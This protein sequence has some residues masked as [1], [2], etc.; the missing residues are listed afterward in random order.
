MK[1][2]KIYRN[3]WG[4]TGDE[5]HVMLPAN[6][7]RENTCRSKH[8]LFPLPLSHRPTFH[9]KEV[10]E[11][12]NSS[13]VSELTSVK[14]SSLYLKRSVIDNITRSITGHPYE[15]T[16]SVRASGGQ[17]GGAEDGKRTAIGLPVACE[18]GRVRKRRGTFGSIHKKLLMRAHAQHGLD[19][20]SERLFTQTFHIEKEGGRFDLGVGI[21][22]KRNRV[23]NCF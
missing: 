21:E 1:T 15:A 2:L 13:K 8:Q 14:R 12:S 16:Q 23:P 5:S 11:P 17:G 20:N 3:L 18:R 7:S 10:P 22:K 19:S 4:I 6:D 9:K